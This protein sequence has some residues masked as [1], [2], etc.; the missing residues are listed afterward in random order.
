[1]RSKII[2]LT[3][4]LTIAIFMITNPSKSTENQKI[5]MPTE[6]L[7]IEGKKPAR[8]PHS[9]HLAIG[10]DCGICH[11]DEEHQ[12]LSSLAIKVMVDS[13]TLHCVSCHNLKHPDKKLQK[14]KDIFHAL[15][16]NC[17]K[18]GYEGKN[19]PTKCTGC[20]IKKSK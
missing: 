14:A 4:T 7:V 13:S 6:E 16:K 11:H 2:T 12:P 3:T 1:M 5:T 15:C 9:T 18:A 8:F 17:H 20:H 10:L 19:G